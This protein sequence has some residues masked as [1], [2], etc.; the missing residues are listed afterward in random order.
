MLVT[1]SL[2]EQRDNIHSS[3]NE[4]TWRQELVSVVYADEAVKS[5]QC[6]TGTYGLET[7]RHD[8]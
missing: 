5:L 6:M 1:V 4:E 3:A 7:V 8:K 2:F